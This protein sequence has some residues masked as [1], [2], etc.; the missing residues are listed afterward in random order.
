MIKLN[1]LFT[2]YII[3]LVTAVDI[4]EHPFH[5]CTEK[6]L[7]VTPILLGQS[8]RRLNTVIDIGG[9]YTW[10]SN[11]LHGKFE[12]GFYCALDNRKYTLTY[13]DNLNLQGE[14]C[15]DQ[16]N[17]DTNH[18]SFIKTNSTTPFISVEEK[19]NDNLI[20]AML[21]MGN[22]RNSPQN[23]YSLANGSKSFSIV[24][25]SP[26]IGSIKFNTKYN[27][28]AST[29][30][31][32]ASC[33]AINT[34][35]VKWGCKLTHIVL[36]DYEYIYKVKKHVVSVFES[37]YYKIYVPMDFFN[38]YY[39]HLNDVNHKCKTMEDEHERYYIQC[40]FKEVDHLRSFN[41]VFD[42]KIFLH[43]NYNTLIYPK[44]NEE[45]ILIIGKVNLD[46]FIFGSIF[47]AHYETIFDA[48]NQKISFV[49]VHNY[50]MKLTPDRKYISF[51]NVKDVF[52]IGIMINSIGLSLLFIIKYYFK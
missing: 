45:M 8:E 1:I 5:I 35:G 47:F 12:Q 38:Y 52:L 18:S 37:I 2:L 41:L 32:Y 14:L 20:Q 10:F 7:L 27:H 17:I 48:N 40:P 34:N 15:Y 3:H 26:Y 11:T 31:P 44:N 6:R 23:Q 36:G 51:I 39:E 28:Y 46:H 33:D 21:A 22:N 43:L 4:I 24:V 16:L 49:P 42:N 50:N 13:E 9:E 30:K 29:T 25:S 19:I